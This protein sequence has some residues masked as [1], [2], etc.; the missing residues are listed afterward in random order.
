MH[1]KSLYGVEIK[2]FCFGGK[3]K[4]INTAFDVN[5]CECQKDDFR[6]L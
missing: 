2:Y 4:A 5:S 3:M 6:L 1:L